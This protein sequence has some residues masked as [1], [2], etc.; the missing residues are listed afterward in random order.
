[1][2]GT[3][4]PENNP[5]GAG[6]CN[7]AFLVLRGPGEAALTGYF[8]L[9]NL[10]RDDLRFAADAVRGA[11]NSLAAVHEG[12]AAEA[13]HRH[14][15]TLE[16]ALAQGTVEVE[17]AVEAV[18]DQANFVRVVRSEVAAIP[19]P[20]LPATT[21]DA[22]S[23]AS[24]E[25]ALAESNRLA[26]EAGERYRGNANLS[27]GARL[28]LFEVPAAAVPDTGPAGTG[29]EG[30]TAIGPAGGIGGAPGGTGVAVPPPTGGA[31]A[32]AGPP[33]AGG[34]AQLPGVVPGTIPGGG[35]AAPRSGQR[36][37]ARP[38][39]PAPRGAVPGPGSPARPIPGVPATRWQPGQPWTGR[40]SPAT[41]TPLRDG[42][43]DGR[44]PTL[45]SPGGVGGTS[46]PLGGGTAE[47]PR[48]AGQPAAGAR[49]PGPG[50][51]PLLPG[52]AAGGHDAEHTRP[53]W[54]LQDD[55]D[56]IWFAGVPE[57][58]DPVVGGGAAGTT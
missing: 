43:R 10:V 51:V 22:A 36:P 24:F 14:L 2:P 44:A 53:P 57:H 20:A 18:H 33:A 7:S 41:G 38:P 17:R 23:M 28:P 50:H 37:V 40:P 48:V 42:V 34:P 16:G 1:M 55:A 27:F 8:D 21:K 39:V 35:S 3:Y 5:F 11:A 13:A 29:G 30:V 31:G 25:T 32:P 15:R 58:V 9:L 49:G 6:T 26:D 52:T 56:A 46:A 54:L 12:V 45:R 19:E 47:A 4:P